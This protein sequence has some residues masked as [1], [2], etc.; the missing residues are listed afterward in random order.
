MAKR[1]IL[2]VPEPSRPIWPAVAASITAAGYDLA[3]LPINPEM[4]DVMSAVQDAGD[5]AAVIRMEEHGC[6]WYLRRFQELVRWL[7]GNGIPYLYYDYAYLD[8]YST[9]L[10]EPYGAM[11]AHSPIRRT[12]GQVPEYPLWQTADERLGRYRSRVTGAYERALAAGPLTEPGYVCLWLAFH[13]MYCR[14]PF[15]PPLAKGDRYDYIAERRG[16]LSWA[17]DQVKA[18][19]GRPVVKVSN[20]TKSDIPA[21]V[22]CWTDP[23]PEINAR[24][25]IYAHNNVIVNSSVSNE[26]ALA[27]MPVSAIGRSWFSGLGVF[28]EPD[29]W[30][31]AVNPA[32]IAA[33]ART[34]WLNWWLRNQVYPGA[35]GQRVRE[36]L[37]SW[38]PDVV[39][40]P[41]KYEAIYADKQRFGY[42]HTNHGVRA[43][44]LLPAR[45][46]SIVDVGCGGNEFLAPFRALGCR[47]IG[48]DFAAPEADVIADATALPFGDG[49]FEWAVSFDCLEHLPFAAV[50]LAIREMARV[51]SRF[52]ISIARWPATRKFPDGTRQPL[53]LTVRPIAW[54]LDQLRDAG[55][56]DL[57]RDVNGYIHGSWRRQ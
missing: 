23:A 53:H 45:P 15:R 33:P 35:A 9:V 52:V 22:E 3:P 39:P 25:M 17:C 12:W 32:P 42:G 31:E 20:E 6:L 50:P 24:L 34:R 57:E 8:H 37:S 27:G 7:A 5:V 1:K 51:S 43:Y 14:P 41:A 38:E 4:G 2:Y 36:L 16:W 21:G 28:H 56:R 44:G 46:E 26:M 48:V 49:E 19:G 13:T 54:W 18:H 11:T 40:E 55:A 30:A 29:S 10:I 47:A